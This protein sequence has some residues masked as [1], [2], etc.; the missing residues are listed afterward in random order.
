MN[1]S[2][3]NKLWEVKNLS[4]CVRTVNF[5]VIFCNIHGLGEVLRYLK[6]V[7]QFKWICIFKFTQRIE[8]NLYVSLRLRNY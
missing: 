7:K 4:L 6:W 5:C 3:E 1:R 2:S 8:I